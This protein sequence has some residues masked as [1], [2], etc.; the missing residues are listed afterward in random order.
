MQAPESTSEINPSFGGARR[1]LHEHV[2]GLHE[3]LDRLEAAEDLS[4]DFLLA[5][6]AALFKM[7]ADRFAQIE[8]NMKL[9]GRPTPPAPIPLC[10]GQRYLDE[11]RA[12]PA[13]K[14]A[15]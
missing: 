14:A 13:N 8:H 12:G 1:A 15:A 2:F 3:A 9:Y 5:G 11:L 4:W 7:G 10:E 6:A